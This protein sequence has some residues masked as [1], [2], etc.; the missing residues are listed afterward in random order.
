MDTSSSVREYT[1]QWFMEQFAKAKDRAI[2]FCEPVKHDL[3]VRRPANNAWSVAECYS[4]LNEFG[5]VYLE[6]IRRGMKAAPQELQNPDQAFPPR[7]LWKGVI[8]LFAP[9]YTMKMK[10]VDP[11]APKK[12]ADLKKELVLDQFLALQDD[13]IN[14]LENARAES[15]NLSNTKVSNPLISFLKMTLS[16][17]F[18]VAEVHQR[19]HQWQAEQVFEKIK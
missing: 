6:N 17:C 16:E 2:D 12:T 13:F 5:E 4:H 15:I 14:E 19:R 8:K 10:T 9:P 7:L 11:F 1:F 3:F 18:A